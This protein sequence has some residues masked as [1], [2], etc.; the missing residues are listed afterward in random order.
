MQT[1]T[2]KKPA[3]TSFKGQKVEFETLAAKLI[4]KP[5][6]KE[7][8]SELATE[9]SLEDEGGGCFVVVRQSPDYPSPE[10]SGEIKIDQNEW[11]A[12]KSAIERM[13]KVATA[14]NSKEQ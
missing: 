9:V 13:V 3:T 1:S 14:Q 5:K 8:Y 4:V 11:P 12:I 7:I 10:K 6:T 2:K